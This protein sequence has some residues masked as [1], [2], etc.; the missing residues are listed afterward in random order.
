MMTIAS[1][2]ILRLSALAILVVEWFWDTMV[3]D[4]RNREGACA[5]ALINSDCMVSGIPV[6]LFVQQT[7][8][9][10]NIGTAAQ[11]QVHV[12]HTR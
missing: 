4:N 3:C 5:L 10:S 11:A 1:S 2:N 8:Q 6:S 7:F 12:C 9:L